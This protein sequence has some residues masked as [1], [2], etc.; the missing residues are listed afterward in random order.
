M[1]WNSSGG[2]RQMRGRTETYKKKDIRSSGNL[3]FHLPGQLFSFFT[4]VISILLSPY[5]TVFSAISTPSS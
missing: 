3:F 1:S 5:R 2:R 4:L